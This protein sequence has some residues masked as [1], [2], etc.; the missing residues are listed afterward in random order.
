[1]EEVGCEWGLEDNRTLTDWRVWRAGPTG[2]IKG[3]IPSEVMQGH[4]G[5]MGPPCREAWAV[6][7]GG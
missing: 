7:R 4:Q 3:I 5:T 2:V 1:M 6:G